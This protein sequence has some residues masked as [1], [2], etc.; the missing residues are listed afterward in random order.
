MFPQS[1]DNP[2]PIPN[3][4]SYPTPGD[5]PA[6]CVLLLHGPEQL[7][8]DG[9]AVGRELGLPPSP[10]PQHRVSVGFRIVLG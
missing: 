9:R 10:R 1:I 8:V 4:N 7:P 6:P 2:N 5:A 3:F